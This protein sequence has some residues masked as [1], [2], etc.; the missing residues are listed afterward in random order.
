MDKRGGWAPLGIPHLPYK[1]DLYVILTKDP[2]NS[3]RIACPACESGAKWEERFR[4]FYRCECCDCGCRFYVIF[5]PEALALVGKDIKKPRKSPQYIHTTLIA[6][7]SYC[8]EHG[9]LKDYTQLIRSRD[10]VEVCPICKKPIEPID[11]EFDYK[12]ELLSRI[13]PPTLKRN[14]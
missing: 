14:E 11:R 9:R 4:L 10:M 5:K 3:K 1:R 2:I 8:A 13:K 12:R 7:T 6:D